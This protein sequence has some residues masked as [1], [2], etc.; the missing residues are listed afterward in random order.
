MSV[1]AQNAAMRIRHVAH[2]YHTY[3]SKGLQPITIIRLD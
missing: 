2:E 3:E 1:G